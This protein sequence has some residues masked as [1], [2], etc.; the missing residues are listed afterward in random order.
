MVNF[1]NNRGFLFVSADSGMRPLLAYVEKGE[2]TGNDL[3]GGTQLWIK[4]TIDNVEL[5]RKGKVNN[6]KSAMAAWRAY[7]NSMTPFSNNKATN[8]VKRINV[9]PPNESDPCIADPNYTSTT[10]TSVGPLLPIQ[11]GQTDTYNDLFADMSCTTSFNGRPPTGCVATAMAQVIRYWQFPTVYN[12]LSMPTDHGNL[13]VQTLM[14]NVGTSINM[15]YACS[16]SAPPTESYFLG[17]LTNTSTSERVASSLVNNFGYSSSNF[18]FYDQSSS[19]YMTAKNEVA[20]NRPVIL[21]GYP[22]TDFWQNPSGAG[23]SWVMDGYLET[24]YI[25]CQNGS[26]A[27]STYLWFHM[28]WGWQ[29]N[30]TTTN[31]NGW[32]AYD[33]W[34]IPAIG[35]GFVYFNQMVYNIHP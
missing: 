32:F 2:F 16:G 26:S 35:T 25:Y 18:K 31:Y 3:P 1:A 15:N 30:G 10:Q 22:N 6:W 27:G 4:K 29:E 17:N 23:H 24:T 5:V 11:W 33:N 19:D 7:F 12:Y 8:N 28:N 20:N 14:M 21:T 9:L 13:E 34:Y